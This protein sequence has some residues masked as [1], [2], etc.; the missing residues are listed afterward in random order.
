VA[1]NGLFFTA[2]VDHQLTMIHWL[3]A[4][5]LVFVDALHSARLHDSALLQRMRTSSSVANALAA[6]FSTATLL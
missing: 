5:S 3:D 6:I 4:I 2:A 1:W